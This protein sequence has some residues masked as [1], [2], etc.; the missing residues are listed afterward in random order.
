MYFINPVFVDQDALKSESG[1]DQARLSKL[2]F[3]YTGIWWYARY[4]NHFASDIDTPNK[5]LG[6]LLISSDAGQVA[7]LVKYLKKDN[8]IQQLQ[9]E[10]FKRAGNPLLK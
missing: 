7:E 9:E 3:A 2:P 6:E 10:F 8:T 5:R 4:P 1:L